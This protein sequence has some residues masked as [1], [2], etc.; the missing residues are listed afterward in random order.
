[1]FSSTL[2]DSAWENTHIVDTHP[3][4]VIEDLRRQNGGDIIVLASNSII[5]Q[6]LEA[7]VLDCLSITLC[8][9][10]AGGGERLFGNG[11][12]RSS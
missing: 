11:L 7:D 12:P 4:M 3:A 5:K 9:E 10:I 1:V 6:L 8:P 2:K